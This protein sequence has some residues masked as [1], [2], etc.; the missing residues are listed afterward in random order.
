[1]TETAHNCRLPD[2]EQWPL[3]GYT[4]PQ[5][6]QRWLLVVA[7]FHGNAAWQRAEVSVPAPEPVDHHEALME[8][9]A[10]AS[11]V[12]HRGLP[13]GV[14]ENHLKKLAGRLAGDLH[15]APS[16]IRLVAE[17]RAALAAY[18]IEKGWRR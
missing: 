4:C 6:N 5:C 2:A 11:M 17:E 18:L 15:D 8:Q 7:R 13:D 14:H 9:E 16:P 3:N 12:E 10:T 1:V